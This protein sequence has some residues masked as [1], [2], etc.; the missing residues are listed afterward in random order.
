MSRVHFKTNLLTSNL[1]C[2]P[3][4]NKNYQK[5]TKHLLFNDK[6]RISKKFISNMKNTKCL[7]FRGD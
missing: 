4:V 7:R 3:F 2:K 5:K 1:L 6:N